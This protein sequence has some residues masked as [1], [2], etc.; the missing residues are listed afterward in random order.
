MISNPDLPAYKYDPYSK[1][2]TRE[3]YDHPKMLEMRKASVDKASQ[4]K[5][6]G[7]ILGTLGRQGSRSVLNVV[8]YILTNI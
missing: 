4:A 8:Y 6:V 2:L 5:K 1:K 3:Y 7:I